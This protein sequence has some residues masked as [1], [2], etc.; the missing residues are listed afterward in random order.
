MEL[1]SKRNLS[2]DS[3]RECQKCVGHNFVRGQ[4][5]TVPR[6][7]RANPRLADIELSVRDVNVKN[8]QGILF[9][10]GQKYDRAERNPG[11]VDVEPSGYLLTSQ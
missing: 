1:S 4:K 7:G 3:R 6:P 2:R 8:A 10:R 11:P 5:P 9:V